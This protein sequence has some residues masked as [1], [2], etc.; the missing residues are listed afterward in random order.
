MTK[1]GAPKGNQ[2]ART[3]GF[4][5]QAL[6]RAEQTVMAH[7]L[8]HGTPESLDQEIALLRARLLQIVH[9]DPDNTHLIIEAASAIARLMRTRYQLTPDHAESLSDSVRDVLKGLGAAL[10]PA[11]ATAAAG[12]LLNN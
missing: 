7:A 5:S 11:A 8:E 9:A 6:T 1:R 12:K 3:H 2:N 10:L 4:Y